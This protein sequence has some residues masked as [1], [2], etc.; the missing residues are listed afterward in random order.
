MRIDINGYTEFLEAQKGKKMDKGKVLE[1]VLKEVLK[2]ET[3]LEKELFKKSFEGNEVSKVVVMVDGFDEISPSYKET[4]IDM[5]QVLKQTSLEQL[6][7]TTRPHLREDLEDNLH[8]LSYTLQPF[9]EV[10]QVEFLKKFWLQTLKIEDTDQHRLQIY[11]KALISKLEQSI[12]DKDKEFTG[13][14]LQTRMLAE[15]FAEDFVSFYRSEKSHP[16]FQHKLD[17][18]GLYRRFIDRKYNIYFREKCKIPAGNVAVVGLRQ[19]LFKQL[20]EKHELLALA[21]LF[22][23]DQ[24]TFLQNDHLSTLLD[25][26]LA[27]IGIVQRNNEGKPK[28]IHRTFAEYFVAEFLINHLTGETK[29]HTQVQ[30][31][32]I[33]KILLRTDCHVIR[34]FLD[35]LLEKCCPT[36]KALEEYGEKLDEHWNETEVNG[37][38]VGFKTALHIAATESNANII[39]L[40]LDSLQSREHSKAAKKML[41]AKDDMGETAWHL[42]AEND[43]VQAMKKI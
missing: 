25:E 2:F 17:L 29:Q 43:S 32:L 3:H 5:L 9:S 31:F 19:N 38:L 34:V 13:I 8:R 39:G 33:R 41:L 1:F 4:V 7:V 36:E 12:R 35:G 23:E 21:A 27:R 14:P 40:L 15:A 16:E 20:Q 26:E 24:V 10:E 42:A 28:F 30:E 11:A 22:T 37:I 6:W 18:L